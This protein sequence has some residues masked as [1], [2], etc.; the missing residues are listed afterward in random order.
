[1][2]AG[3]LAE[4]GELP[5][6]EQRAATPNSEGIVEE[7]FSDNEVE[8]RAYTAVE[9]SDETVEDAEDLPGVE[10]DVDLELETEDA[11]EIEPGEPVKPRHE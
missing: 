11:E 2:A 6:D 9:V 10:V 8:T 3:E 1:M 7:E 5:F 4:P